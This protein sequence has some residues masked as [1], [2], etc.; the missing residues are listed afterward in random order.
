[1]QYKELPYDPSRVNVATDTKKPKHYGTL[2]IP[3]LLT[4][5]LNNWFDLLD[6]A[7]RFDRLPQ[8]LYKTLTTEA[9][10]CQSANRNEF[11]KLEQSG[12]GKFPY[13]FHS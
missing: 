3:N 8:T 2:M 11:L 7:N 6:T 4:I 10:K 12:T 13:S 5:D 1:M 9:V